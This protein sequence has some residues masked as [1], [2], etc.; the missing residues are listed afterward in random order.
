MVDPNHTAYWALISTRWRVVW[1]DSLLSITYDRAPANPSINHHRP[2]ESSDCDNISYI[3]CMKRL[4]GIGV[5]IICE[6]SGE[7][8]SQH[9]LFLIVRHRDELAVLMKQASHHLRVIASCRSMKDQ[10]EYW[11]LSLHR[12]YITSELYR[13][14]LRRW[15]LE[16]E[17][18]AILKARCIESLADT[19]E[20]FLGLQNITLFARTSWA[21]VHR[22]LSSALLLG[23]LKEPTRNQ[24]IRTLL[25]RL[26]VVLADMS[27]TLNGPEVPMPIIRSVS[28]LRR[29]NSHRSDGVSF[30]QED[31]GTSPTRSYDGDTKGPLTFEFAT[32]SA[33]DVSIGRSPYAMMDK[34]LWD[35]QPDNGEM[36]S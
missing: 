24:Y 9:E 15:F 34:I 13:P 6:R 7:P 26:I 11:N 20:A 16:P 30:L 27:S 2:F 31:S 3:D 5:S 18:V 33:S 21:A 19:V 28:A 35:S 22:S 1:Q 14:A 17:S 10:L 25:D 23:I 12:S 8:N 29:L 4:C 32:S 36:R